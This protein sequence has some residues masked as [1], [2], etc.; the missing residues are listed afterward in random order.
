M[1]GMG[2]K[3]ENLEAKGGSWRNLE[4]RKTTSTRWRECLEARMTR[5]M[6]RT[7]RDGESE[8]RQRNG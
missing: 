4:P 3:W 2:S 6:G 7:T 5:R 8:R 1:E